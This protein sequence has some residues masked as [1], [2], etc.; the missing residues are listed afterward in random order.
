MRKEEQKRLRCDVSLRIETAHTSLSDTIIIVAHGG[1]IMALLDQLSEP[2]KDYFD[3]QVKPGEGV[4]GILS[5]N[6]DR[7]IVITNTVRIEG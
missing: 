6:E 5:V 3:W 7:N 1:T 4:A 2:H